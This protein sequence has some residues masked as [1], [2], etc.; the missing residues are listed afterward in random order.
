MVEA[1]RDISMEGNFITESQEPMG[2]SVV[3]ESPLLLTPDEL[4]IIIRGKIT[5][6]GKLLLRNSGPKFHD[7]LRSY[8]ATEF[9]G[10][11]D[12][13]AA[14]IPKG[15]RVNPWVASRIGQAQSAEEALM[16]DAKLGSTLWDRAERTLGPD[17]FPLIKS[18]L[19]NGVNIPVS[20]SEHQNFYLKCMGFL[21]QAIQD[22]SFRQGSNVRLS[23]NGESYK[24]E[25]MKGLEDFYDAGILIPTQA[26][27]GQIL[28]T[29]ETL[30]SGIKRDK[31]PWEKIKD[32][33][34]FLSS[35][36]VKD[37]D[38]LELITDLP[39][40]GLRKVFAQAMHAV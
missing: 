19:R 33:N 13:P 11:I 10:R 14:E 36:S 5:Q 37:R 34:G 30:P 1:F 2:R 17:A 4:G 20:R 23:S 25:T 26:V 27:S 3:L 18:I 32:I 40:M 29:R 35:L 21:S 38:G 7:R 28:K 12:N 9:V 31:F 39:P 16:M 6:D 8:L 24:A 22:V 15:G